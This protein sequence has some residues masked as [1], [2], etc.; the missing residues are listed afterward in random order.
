MEKAKKIISTE[1]NV[2]ISLSAWI[3][4]HNVMESKQ[5]ALMDEFVNKMYKQNGEDYF[6]IKLDV[7]K[8]LNKLTL[9]SN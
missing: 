7:L 2:M 1:G 4:W 9:K 8:F 5:V 3:K 6:I